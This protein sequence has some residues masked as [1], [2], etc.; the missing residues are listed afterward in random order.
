MALRRLGEVAT[1]ESIALRRTVAPVLRPAPTRQLTQ[2]V[3][4]DNVV[5]TRA[6]WHHDNLP[7]T[8]SSN[9][10]QSVLDRL[11]RTSIEIL[12][13]PANVLDPMAL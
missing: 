7:V 10:R 9:L 3:G 13:F 4:A 6:S 11:S 8:Q 12:E 2:R 1:F 5:A